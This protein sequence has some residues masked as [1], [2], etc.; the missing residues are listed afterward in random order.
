MGDPLFRRV[1]DVVQRQVAG[2]VFLVPIRGHLAD[3][4]ELFVLSETGRSI[5]EHLD[6]RH[7]VDDLVA[8]LVA[9]FEVEQEQAQGD[10]LTFLG[11]LEEAGLIEQAVE[12]AEV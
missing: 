10:A 6:G 11:Q 12:M 4:Q 9:E 3:L 7:S 8:G 2:E 1:N 5:W